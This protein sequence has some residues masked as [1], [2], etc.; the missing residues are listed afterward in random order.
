MATAQLSP[1][2]GSNG[3]QRAVH[4]LGH[5]LGVAAHI[6]VAAGCRSRCVADSAQYRQ[7]HSGAAAQAQQPGEPNRHRRCSLRTHR[8]G[9]GLHSAVGRRRA[10]PP[11][12]DSSPDSQRM[13]HTSA[14]CASIRCCTYSFRDCSRENA[15]CSCGKQAGGGGGRGRGAESNAAP[16]RSNRVPA[17]R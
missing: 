7:G 3:M 6:Q 13:P 11:P 8:P 12:A 14:A 16:R 10:P 5:V 15:T 4:I 2:L 9:L 17:R 1:H